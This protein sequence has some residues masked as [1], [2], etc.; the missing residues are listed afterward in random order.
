[1]VDH[2]LARSWILH[3]KPAQSPTL[4]SG[5][6]ILRFSLTSRRPLHKACVDGANLSGIVPLRSNPVCREVQLR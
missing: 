6:D 3:L 5:D 2:H 1:M 4:D